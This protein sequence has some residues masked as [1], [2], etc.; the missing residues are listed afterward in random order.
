M[1]IALVVALTDV[2]KFTL[3]VVLAVAVVASA[4]AQAPRQSVPAADLGRL[5][6][7]ALVLY[8]VGAL[9][10]LS[11]HSILAGL[12]FGAGV[13][14]ASLA[15][16]L[17]RGHDQEDPPD[18]VDPVDAPSPTEPDGAPGFDWTSFEREFRL[19]AARRAPPAPRR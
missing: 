19:Y 10:W 3:A 13:A 12:V 11:H 2:W 8:A 4:C 1:E 17:A 7:G 16:W 6:A 14:V 15:A 18:A 9:A 5:V